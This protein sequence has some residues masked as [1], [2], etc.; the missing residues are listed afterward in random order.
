M[1]RTFVQNSVIRVFKTTG[2]VYH[3]VVLTNVFNTSVPIHERFDLK[4]CLLPRNYTYKHALDPI[5]RRTSVE[6]NN[7]RAVQDCVASSPSPVGS[8]DQA[9]T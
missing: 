8:P 5:A 7:S 3:F 6:G 2:N 9:I 1:G 4:A